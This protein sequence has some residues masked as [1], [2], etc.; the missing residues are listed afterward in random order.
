MG[1]AVS[2]ALALKAMGWRWMNN[3]ILMNKFP[4]LCCGSGAVS[5]NIG[6][7]VWYL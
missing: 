7:L 4:L 3:G 1:R 6:T 2:E 5:M